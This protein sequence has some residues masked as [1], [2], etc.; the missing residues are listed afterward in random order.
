MIPDRIQTSDALLAGILIPVQ[1]SGGT[2]ENS[3]FASVFAGMMEIPFSDGAATGGALATNEKSIAPDIITEGAENGLPMGPER[4]S[5]DDVI[6]ET[7]AVAGRSLN[8]VVAR[9]TDTS[10]PAGS[11]DRIRAFSS[12]RSV[13]RSVVTDPGDDVSAGEPVVMFAVSTMMS[14]PF[15]ETETDAESGVVYIPARIESARFEENGDVI[16]FTA[17]VPD[18]P[19]DPPNVVRFAEGMKTIPAKVVTVSNESGSVTDSI[20]EIRIPSDTGTRTVEWERN[21][22]PRET[23]PASMTGK[24]FTRLAANESRTIVTDA[25]MDG[26]LFAETAVSQRDTVGSE[27]SAGRTERMSDAKVAA[28]SVSPDGAEIMTV[29]APKD[30]SEPSA[31]GPRLVRIEFVLDGAHLE[32]AVERTI[33]G[34]NKVKAI[35]VSPV[36]RKNAASAGSSMAETGA[37]ERAEFVKVE[38]TSDAAPEPTV[39]SKVSR[40]ADTAKRM[41]DLLVSLAESSPVEAVFRTAPGIISEPAAGIVRTFEPTGDAGAFRT[42]RTVAQ[43]TVVELSPAPFELSVVP[44]E[45]ADSRSIE[46]AAAKPVSSKERIFSDIGRVGRAEQRDGLLSGFVDGEPVMSVQEHASEFIPARTLSSSNTSTDPDP[47]VA[48]SGTAAP[49][50][51]RIVYGDSVEIGRAHV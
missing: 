20:P 18:K 27:A 13:S 19:S 14:G 9:E 43:E 26:A 50:S 2:G 21:I 5:S 38:V 36:E 48:T 40:L 4:M 32:G 49:V 8:T 1:D 45:P 41:T 46:S 39:S 22:L 15:H 42:S 7:A 30:T 35:P 3:D 11:I 47:N 6:L 29:S 37:G 31:G 24:V 10:G 12:E 23:M 25:V 17:V 51:G 28:G 34:E 33:A 16:V 44:D